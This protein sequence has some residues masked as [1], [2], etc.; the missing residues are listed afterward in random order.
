[1]KYTCID[2]FSGA[3]GLALGFREVGFEIRLSFDNDPR[4]IETQK[5]NGKYLGHP[6]ILASFEEMDNGRL[7]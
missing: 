4:C 5:M 7:L 1:M 3:G 2:S 6:A